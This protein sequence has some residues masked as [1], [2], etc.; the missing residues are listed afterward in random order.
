MTMAMTRWLLGEAD[1][2]DL[3]DPMEGPPAAHA[4]RQLGV[5]AALAIVMGMA[6][7]AL[8]GWGTGLWEVTILYA[9]LIVGAVAVAY[10]W[11]TGQQRR[12]GGAVSRALV[13]AAI[14]ARDEAIAVTDAAGNLVCANEAYGERCGGYPSPF[15]LD[16]GAGEE[17]SPLVAAGELA[18]SAGVGETVIYRG[19][20]G[21]PVALRVVCR[22]AGDP[23]EHL[24][25]QVSPA[26]MESTL[27]ATVT[28][29]A[30][31][32]GA[33]LAGA[34][35]GAIVTDASGRV[36]AVNATTAAWRQL[37]MDQMPGSD[38]AA[39]VAVSE[40]RQ[41]YF[42]AVDGAR[43]PVRL[44]EL[45][46]VPA[47]EVEAEGYLFALI[48]GAER[49]VADATQT[50]RAIDALL[51]SL[52]LGLATV[53]HNSRFLHMAPGF[54]A[55]A[56]V[57]TPGDLLYPSE[58]V[59]EEDATMVADVVRRVA[60]GH[61]KSRDLQ[62]RLRGRPEDS[63]RMSVL[64][65]TGL[66]EAAAVLALWDDAEQRK[67]QQQITQA[68]K[69]QAVGQLAGGVAHDFNNILTAIIG[70]CDLMLLRHAPGDADFGD[71]NQI[72]Q[73]ANRAANLVRQLLAFSRQQTLRPQVLQ[74]TDVLAE[75][76]NLLK[77]LIG[78]TISLRINHGRNLGPVRVDPGQLEQVI[79]NLVVNARDAMNGV[80]E[81]TIRTSQVGPEEVRRLGHEIMPPA[82]YVVI[83][84][85]D[86][87]CGI[88]P[89]NL[90]KIFEPFFTTK[91]VGKGTGLGLSTV[92]GIV[93][94][95]GGFIFAESE[96]GRGTTFILYLPVH[97]AAET[98]QPAAASDQPPGAAAAEPVPDLWGRG[99]VLLVE[100]E[101]MVRAV[102][103]RA[104]ERKGYEVLTATNGEEALELL[105]ARAEPVDLL[106][107]D[108]VMPTM[109]GPTLVGHA[110]QRYP[111][112]RIIFISGYAEEQLRRSIDVPDV[113]FLP[114]PFS[115][116]QLAEAVREALARVPAAADTDAG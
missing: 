52:P 83:A 82:D 100:D 49:T 20:E 18:R 62:V 86:T 21:R 31:H 55:A 43:M 5:S 8:I 6:S 101:A 99:T 96:L 39:M 66:H 3:P 108:V 116:Q 27:S 74:V 69:M 50:T 56:G 2:L 11:S 7:A 68:T 92:Y 17:G 48:A 111:D 76:S 12:G 15:H 47:G 65:V 38:I 44:V 71:L 110:R 79:V 22:P 94:Q 59:H 63:I 97:A 90:S 102:A 114:K 10:A 85:S 61:L 73:N 107:S 70:Y 24:I 36:L 14:D 45:P 103:K 95:T 87:G 42:N 105:E 64:H 67:L 106:I 40:D 26:D 78:E 104:L 81:L 98:P 109:D 112:L 115:V 25:W 13:R 34:G 19:G 46:I 57:A 29:V 54:C 28:A 41:V 58:L 93:K 51:D 30:G 33:W 35:V 77:R 32:V 23:G 89:E 60:L 4:S 80:G 75:L 37:S 84:V 9:G 91:E 16:G 1:S 53:D 72:R 113:A 88:P